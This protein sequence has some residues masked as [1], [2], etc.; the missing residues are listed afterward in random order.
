MT[1]G[2]D[3]GMTEGP[4]RGMTE[5]PDRGM[6]EGSE[7]E[8][9]GGTA[10]RTA[11]CD[12]LARPLSFL[13]LLVA[14]RTG[15][16]VAGEVPS[17]LGRSG[18]SPVCRSGLPP[19][20]LAGEGWGEGGRGRRGMTGKCAPAGNGPQ[21]R[22]PPAGDRTPSRHRGSGSGG[23]WRVLVG[24]KA[25]RSNV[26]SPRPSPTGRGSMPAACPHCCRI[27]WGGSLRARE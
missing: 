16:P 12:H 21:Q 14:G 11:P 10:G 2:P 27:S 15:D 3:R 25:H 22:S 20:P 6:T 18:P 8:G 13:H 9:Q 19:S 7:R 17:S 24:A 1:E 5:G 23:V 4:G 26:P